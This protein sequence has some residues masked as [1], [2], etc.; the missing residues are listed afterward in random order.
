[1]A[2]FLNEGI[3]TEFPIEEDSLADECACFKNGEFTTGCEMMPHKGSKFQMLPKV[4][5]VLCQN[6]PMFLF[7]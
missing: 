7:I 3:F 1:M 6:R 5:G 4:L 2:L